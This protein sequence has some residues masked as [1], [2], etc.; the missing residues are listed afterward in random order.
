MDTTHNTPQSDDSNKI[1]SNPKRTSRPSVWGAVWRIFALVGSTHLVSHYILQGGTPLLLMASIVL[2]GFAYFYAI[3]MRMFTRQAVAE[4]GAREGGWIYR[5]LYRGTFTK[6]F[7]LI[8]CVCF[9]A[10]FLLHANQMPLYIWLSL[11][12]D[13]GVIV[14][15]LRQVQ[16]LAEGQSRPVSF[17]LFGRKL[18][19]LANLL[20]MGLI[21]TVTSFFMPVEDLRSF[22]MSESFL[23][24]WNAI[25]NQGLDPVLSIWAGAISGADQ[26]TWNLMQQLSQQNFAS[27]W[28]ILAWSIFFIVQ[29]VYLMVIHYAMLGTMVVAEQTG[30][31]N[32][33]L[34]KTRAAKWGWGIFFLL[35][36]I[37]MGAGVAFDLKL[38]HFPTPNTPI[39]F[40]TAPIRTIT[41]DLCDENGKREQASEAVA[42]SVSEQAD[43]EQEQFKKA[44]DDAIDS[45][46]NAAFANAFRGVDRYLDW[47][48]TITGEW[49]RIGTL[50]V[51]DVGMLMQD[52]ME[53]LIMKQSGAEALLASTNTAITNQAQKQLAAAGKRVVATIKQNVKVAKCASSQKITIALP[54]LSRDVDRMAFATSTALATGFVVSKTAGAAIATK[55]AASASSK[56]AAKM[57]AKMAAKAAM[58]SASSWAGA[59]TGA[60]AGLSCGPLA[61]VCSTVL[62][63]TGFIGVDALFMKGDEILNRTD[64]RN[65]LI[66]QLGLQRDALRAQIK[67]QVHQTGNAYFLQLKTKTNAMFVPA[68]NGV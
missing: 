1:T 47:Y 30:W 24:G 63:V 52:K 3:E 32:A 51:G 60:V 61:L 8:L 55:L 5:L 14:L 54:E 10:S 35:M 15:L 43:K 56:L 33:L 28:K 57:I 25:Q 67:E 65:D 31:A 44:M 59:A 42:S 21:V 66:R 20:T 40:G 27:G 45:H 49:E 19:S 7:T 26:A 58:Q 17:G 53:T 2:G 13:A 50:A 29:V 34:G 12:L 4:L 68:R 36:L 37:W 48:F 62:G 6:L 16:P 38:A 39:H 18:T 41:I 23:M 64:I 9:A 22:G 11:Y 46:V